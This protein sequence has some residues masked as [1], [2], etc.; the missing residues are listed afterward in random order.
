[1]K[2]KF[3]Y[4]G[5]NTF[6]ISLIGGSLILIGY[7]LSGSYN[8]AFLGAYYIILAFVINVIVFISEIISAVIKKENRAAHIN[9]AILLLV[10]IPI[11]FLYLFIFDKFLN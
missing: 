11:V 1:M 2:A 4:E 8:F 3:N 5:R 6:L 7:L 9:S 10:N